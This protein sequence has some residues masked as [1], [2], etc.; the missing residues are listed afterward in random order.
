MVEF[1]PRSGVG[2]GS[3]PVGEDD[4]LF[5]LFFVPRVILDAEFIG[6]GPKHLNVHQS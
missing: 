4:C 5:F 3:N 6:D 2:P 1:E